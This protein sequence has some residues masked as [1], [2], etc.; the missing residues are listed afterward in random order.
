MNETNKE[1][2]IGIKLLSISLWL[3]LYGALIALKIEKWYQ[4]SEVPLN[5][6]QWMGLFLIVEIATFKYKTWDKWYSKPSEKLFI[7]TLFY[8]IFLLVVWLLHFII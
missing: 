3:I 5:Y 7:S 2:I 1:L 6:K 4:L 8:S